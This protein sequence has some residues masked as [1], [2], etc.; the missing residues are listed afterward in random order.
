MANKWFRI[1]A[2]IDL[3]NK[4]I[5]TTLYDRDTVDGDGNMAILNKKAFTIAAPDAD[6]A[7]ADYPTDIDLSN[8]YFNIYMDK[9][10]N[11]TNKMEYYFDNI[12]LEYQDYE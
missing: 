10:A 12:T 1:T 3:V 4:T 9:K 7:N 5:T 6:G 11:T 8:L 2:D